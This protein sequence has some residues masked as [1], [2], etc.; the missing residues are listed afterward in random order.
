MGILELIVISISL[1]M[2]AF[3]VSL[4]KG[5]RM[6][7]INYRQGLIISVTFGF[8]QALMPFLGWALGIQFAQYITA[9]DHWVAFVLLLGIG[10]KMLWDAF[11]ED[12]SCPMPENEKIKVR[13]LLTLA[14]A[15]S[16]DAL[17]VGI[18]FAFL[19]V[20]IF[21]A[22]SIIGSITLIIS[23]IGILL[24]NRFGTRFQGKAEIIGG[25]VLILIGAKIL[26]SH[27]GILVL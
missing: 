23:F 1:A 21:E 12:G 20:H 15:T 25:V 16:I 13:E 26:F 2:D 10:C 9:Y 8:F 3:A 18:T 14:L 11:H 4:C 22:I 17:A 5:L 7:T 27:L 24:G 19:Q 6:T